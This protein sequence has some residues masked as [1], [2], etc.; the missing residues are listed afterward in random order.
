MPLWAL[1]S[2]LKFLQVAIVLGAVEKETCLPLRA[3]NETIGGQQLLH[4]ARLPDAGPRAVGIG[5]VPVVME[6]ARVK[7]H[8]AKRRA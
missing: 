4:H 5:S 2:Y 8:L 7:T 6:H 3:L 1:T